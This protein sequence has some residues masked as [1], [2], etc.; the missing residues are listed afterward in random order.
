M[1]SKTNKMMTWLLALS[2]TAG[3]S[4]KNMSAEAVGDSAKS[5][6]KTEAVDSVAL[7][8]RLKELKSLDY[9]TLPL[10][11]AMCYAK[12]IP[13]E[14][15]YVC[16]VCGKTSPSDSYT[17]GNIESI[18]RVVEQMKNMGYDVVLDETM[19][20]NH[21][22]AQNNKSD[23]KKEGDSVVGM[24]R[25]ELIFKIRFSKDAPYHVAKSNVYAEYSAVASFLKSKQDFV[26]FVENNRDKAKSNILVIQKMT[27]LEK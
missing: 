25:P 23:A 4:S 15:E 26:D 10:F 24:Q 19:F 22:S 18:R 7:V 14:A 27:G 20:C 5:E 3:D 16:G 8:D 17:N 9:D 21:C 2:S 12:A 13:I 1:G 11:S 6:K